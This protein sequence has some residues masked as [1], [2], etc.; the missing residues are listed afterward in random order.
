MKK[1][2]PPVIAAIITIIIVL[3]PFPNSDTHLRIQVKNFDGDDCRLYYSLDDAHTFSEEQ[4]VMSTFHAETNQIEFIL[5]SSYAD[6]I[7]GLMIAFPYDKKGFQIHD[8]T[9]SSAGVIQKRISSYKFFSGNNI[10]VF[11]EI[12][13]FTFLPA[14][15]CV[16]LKS[17]KE[18]S[19]FVLG[20]LPVSWIVK[21]NSNYKLSR[22][23]VCLFL[24]ACVLPV[25]Y[26]KKKQ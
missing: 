21:A 15:N 23:F 1:F 17:T 10:E 4:K 3:L 8:L 14:Q 16:F 2:L 18:D 24:S 26:R 12:K 13:D 11:H 20:Q 22:L 25:I 19:Y 7:T 9:L 6:K 5:D